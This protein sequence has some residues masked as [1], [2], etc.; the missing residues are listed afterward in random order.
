MP[1]LTTSTITFFLPG[2]SSSPGWLLVTRTRGAWWCRYR[3]HCR[4]GHRHLSP[5]S[6]VCAQE[7]YPKDKHSLTHPFPSTHAH[8]LNKRRAKPSTHQTWRLRFIVLFLSS[9]LVGDGQ[10]AW[11]LLLRTAPL[12]KPSRCPR[13][14]LT[15]NIS[16]GVQQILQHRPATTPFLTTSTI[17]VA[18]LTPGDSDTWSLMMSLWRT[19]QVRP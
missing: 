7:W 17:P 4:S 19:L 18:C 15:E 8:S 12:R 16:R 3:G 9:V 6:R 11:H 14:V 10:E 2:F 1:F 5:L 13:T